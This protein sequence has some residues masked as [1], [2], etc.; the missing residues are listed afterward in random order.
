M[1]EL[2]RLVRT[3]FLEVTYYECEDPGAPP[4]VLLPGFP[5]DARTYERVADFLTDAGYRPLAS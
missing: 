1:S 3:S 4:V 5:A 2:P